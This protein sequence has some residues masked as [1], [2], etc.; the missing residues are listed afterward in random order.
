MLAL[1]KSP[2][3]GKYDLSSMKHVAS[4]AA[5]L[6]QELARQVKDRLGII[7]T[8]GFGLSEMSPIVCL[9]NVQDALESRTR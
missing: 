8:D 3:V 1:A 9:Q 5:T 4:G 2:E 7:T 6:S